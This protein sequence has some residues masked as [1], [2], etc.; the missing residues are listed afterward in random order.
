MLSC[1]ENLIQYKIPRPLF[2]SQRGKP[3]LNQD[4][5]EKIEVCSESRAGIHR[6]SFDYP[7]IELGRSQLGVT[8]GLLNRIIFI[9]QN[10]MLDI[11]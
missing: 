2:I 11:S 5:N 4:R 6:L 9:N 7:R 3:L 10:D 1:G 8:D